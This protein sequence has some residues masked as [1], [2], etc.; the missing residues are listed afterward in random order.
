[1]REV[2]NLGTAQNITEMPNKYRR[3]GS[4]RNAE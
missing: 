2:L 1:M 4:S 3:K